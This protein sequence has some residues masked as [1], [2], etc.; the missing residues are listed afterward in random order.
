M[1]DSHNRDRKLPR[2]AGAAGASAAAA[3]LGACLVCHDL[4]ESMNF[5]HNHFIYFIM[6]EE[7]LNYL[8][9][10]YSY[11]FMARSFIYKIY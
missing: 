6:V 2:V 1:P 7:V 10:I 4:I 3:Q 9:G 8:C 5:V 11:Y